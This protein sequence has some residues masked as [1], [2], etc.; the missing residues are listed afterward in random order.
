M[1]QSHI[2]DVVLCYCN[3]QNINIICYS[4]K[5]SINA[6]LIPLKVKRCTCCI[7]L[8]VLI[9]RV[10]FMSRD[11]KAVFYKLRCVLLLLYAVM[12][13]ALLSAAAVNQ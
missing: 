1:F 5:M 12:F 10:I 2:Y 9:Y 13:I 11:K 3:V 8:N 7:F 6:S 4:S